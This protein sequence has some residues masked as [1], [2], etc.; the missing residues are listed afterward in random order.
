MG[1]TADEI[2]DALIEGIHCFNVESEAELSLLASI[3]ESLGVTAPVSI[4]VNPDV[5]PKTHPYIATGLLEAKFGLSMNTAL[6]LYRE[7]HQHPHLNMTGI[8]CHIGSQITDIEPFKEAASRLLD[9]TDTLSGDGIALSHIDLGGGI[10]IQYQEEEL[11]D[12]QALAQWLKPLL[13]HRALQLIL[14]PGRSIVADAG[15]LLT[16]VLHTKVAERKHFCVVDAAMND[17]LRPSL[18]GAWQRIETVEPIKPGAPE[19]RYDVVG[20][21]CETGDFLGKDR[22]LVTEPG[23]HLAILDAGAY[24]F[25]MGSNYNTRPRGCEVLIEEGT[26]RVIRRRESLD[27]LLAHELDGLKSS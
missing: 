4:R 8:D 16:R 10:G 23:H 5:D 11:I 24:G 19:I 1:K 21:I 13:D 7:G 17:L 2:R 14:E 9:L 12:L 15:L 25:G 26:A 6:D 27:D 18:Y 3:A 22:P 20:P